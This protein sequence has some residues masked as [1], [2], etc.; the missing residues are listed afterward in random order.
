MGADILGWRACPLQQE[1]GDDGF[2]DKLRLLGYKRGADSVLPAGQRENVPVTIR[3]SGEPV[4]TMTYGDL[5]VA[6]GDFPVG[7][8]ECPAC[9]LSEGRPIGCGRYLAFPIPASIEESLTAFARPELRDPQGSLFAL[10][11]RYLDDERHRALSDGF[12]RRRGAAAGYLAARPR[13]LAIDVDGRPEIDSADLLTVLIAP[14]FEGDALALAAS[15]LEAW[16][17]ARPV[18]GI[19][20]ER[21][22]E[23]ESFARLLAATRD[24]AA[25]LPDAA[26]LLEA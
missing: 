5:V 12:R 7:I 9:P 10:V 15:V 25:T 4:R 16:L 6:L 13:P 22:A 3:T 8:P 14:F 24:L 19:D 17:A 21:W 1:L 2:F 11:T 18:G 23:W 26:V 20:E